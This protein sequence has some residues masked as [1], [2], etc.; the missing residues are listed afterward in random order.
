MA[1]AQR[2]PVGFPEPL[3]TEMRDWC[4]ERG[5]PLAEFIRRGVRLLLDVEE[6]RVLTVDAPAREGGDVL[7]VTL[8][9][10]E[11]VADELLGVLGEQ[12]RTR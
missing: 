6:G 4:A 12:R 8:N 2:F 1:E 3:N 7:V 10:V 5:V 11:V 9:G